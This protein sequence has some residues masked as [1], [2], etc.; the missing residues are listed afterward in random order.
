MVL[1]EGIGRGRGVSRMARLLAIVVAWGSLS[2]STG[3]G[4]AAGSELTVLSHS[5]QA[6]ASSA[7]FV[8]V[9]VVNTGTEPLGRCHVVNERIAPEGPCVLLGYRFWRAPKR[10]TI[11]SIDRAE[12]LRPGETLAPGSH[13]DRTVRLQTPRGGPRGEEQPLLHLYLIRGAGH[14]LEWTHLAVP[15]LPGPVPASVWFREL[16]TRLLFGVYV[17][18]LLWALRRAV[19]GGRKGGAPACSS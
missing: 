6:P 4:P 3:P 11:P 9:Q 14:A 17:L 5:S 8:R 13:V 12:F 18:G 16:G 1:R 15:I 2:A 10:L 7:F 19:R